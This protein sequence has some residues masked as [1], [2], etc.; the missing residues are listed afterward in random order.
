MKHFIGALVM[1]FAIVGGVIV[2]GCNGF[3]PV[4][5]EEQQAP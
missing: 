5:K 3:A 4:E 2:S 1:L